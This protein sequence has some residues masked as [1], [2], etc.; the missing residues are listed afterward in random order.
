MVVRVTKNLVLNK[1]SASVAT[2][3]DSHELNFMAAYGEPLVQVGGAITY[4]NT[5]F[6]LKSSMLAMRNQFPTSLEL[7]TLAD[8]VARDK[9]D[10]WANTVKANLQTALNALMGRSTPNFPNTTVYQFIYVD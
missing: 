3:F 7:D 9:V 2:E 4:N 10:A 8:S 1:Y 5:T 6:N